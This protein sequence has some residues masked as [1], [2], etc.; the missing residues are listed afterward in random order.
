MNTAL[1]HE[2]CTVEPQENGWSIWKKKLKVSKVDNG[3]GL[4]MKRKAFRLTKGSGR[5]TKIEKDWA[6]GR[7]A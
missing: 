2:E 3:Q 7:S 1:K 5:K 4:S 6:L